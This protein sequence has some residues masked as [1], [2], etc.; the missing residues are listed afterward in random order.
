MLPR[1]VLLVM[2]VREGKDGRAW[3]QKGH[4]HPPS[5]ASSGLM[6]I[7]LAPVP[8][9]EPHWKESFNPELAGFTSH[10]VYRPRIVTARP[11]PRRGSEQGSSGNPEAWVGM[12]LRWVRRLLTAE[13]GRVSPLAD[14]QTVLP[15]APGP[16]IGHWN[17]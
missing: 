7:E 4:L 16:H 11:E 10:C 6:G 3:G 14:T 5:V 17:S 9:F 2:P 1:L 13:S 15:L 8:F 12:H